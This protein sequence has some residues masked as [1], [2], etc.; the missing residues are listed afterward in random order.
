MNEK[1]A[2]ALVELQKAKNLVS[3]ENGGLALELRA[4]IEQVS[5]YIQDARFEK[6]KL[7][8]GNEGLPPIDALLEKM[9]VVDAAAEAVIMKHGL[10]EPN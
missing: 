5:P 8:P 4:L 6:S 9:G 10:P 3:L 2:E 7:G 1:R